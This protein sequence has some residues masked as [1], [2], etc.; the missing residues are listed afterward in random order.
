M[1]EG[2]CIHCKSRV[3]ILDLE[4]VRRSPRNGILCYR[5]KCS[6]C[7]GGVGKLSTQELNLEE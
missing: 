3:K 6:V 4:F 5:G 1:V 2:Y 7:G